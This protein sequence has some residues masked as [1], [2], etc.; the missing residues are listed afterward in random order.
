M[1]ARH[2]I[3]R[4][5]G[6]RRGATAVEYSLI[7]GLIALAVLVALPDITQALKSTMVTARE[8]LKGKV[9]EGDPTQ[10]GTQCR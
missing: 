10:D 8:G 7:L 4:L 6:N 1:A 2:L 3:S 5:I 9:C